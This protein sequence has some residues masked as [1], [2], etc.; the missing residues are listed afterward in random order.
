MNR[1]WQ[2]ISTINDVYTIRNNSY[3]NVLNRIDD[4]LNNT[5]YPISNQQTNDINQILLSNNKN[6]NKETLTKIIN[7]LTINQQTRVENQL[8]FLLEMRQ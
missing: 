3:N 8:I 6:I 7:T 1:A 2:I 4:I 5:E